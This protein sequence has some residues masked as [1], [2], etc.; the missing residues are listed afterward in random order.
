MAT[1]ALPAGRPGARRRAF[2][3][4]FD[5]D[6]WGWAGAK[7]TFWFVL[8]IFLVGYIPD[9]AYYFTVE[10]AIDLGVL[11]WSPVNLCPPENEGLPCPPEPGSVLPWHPSPQE[12]AL[13]AGRTDG[14]AVQVGTQLLFVGGSDGTAASTDVYV[15][16]MVGSGNFD[17]WAAGPALP[18]P[19][20][21]AAVVFFGGSVYVIGGADAAGAPT[22]TV[23]SLTPDAEGVLPAEWTDLDDLAL[24]DPRAGAAV[25]A[26]GDGLIVA[27]GANADG[28]TTSVWKAPLATNGELEAWVP[29]Q[30]LY[31]PTVDA[32]MALVGDYLW[33]LG[34]RTAEGPV[35]TVQVGSIGTPGAAGGDGTQGGAAEGTSG[36]GATDGS[37]EGTE[38][39]PGAVTSW[40]VSQQ[41]NLPG[42]RANAAGWTANGVLYLVGGNDGNQLR[43][44]LYWTVPNPDGSHGGWK[45]L[46]GTDLGEG[47]EGSAPVV[48]GSNAFI[49]GGQTASGVTASSARTNLAPQEPF[50]QLGILGATVPALKIEGEI[51]QQLGYLNAFTIGLVNFALLVAVGVAFA[52][53]EKT[54]ALWKRFRRR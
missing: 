54:V 2:F 12:L 36:Q 30:P 47:V 15:A 45:H 27:G 37:G 40:R 11:A 49:L 35:A 8:I 38:L 32:A 20:A 29:Q 10:R 25:V 24:P 46:D 43:P 5:A 21:N 52:N 22:T 9:R 50:F 51:G 3:G 18:E 26:A 16:P 39:D 19:R 31:E 41:T 23:Y 7:A 48:G 13:P 1:Q 33:L 6:G 34:G 28:P 17:R 44:E 53:R 42:P 4:L 14:G